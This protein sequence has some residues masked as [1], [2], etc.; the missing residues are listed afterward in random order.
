MAVIPETHKWS[1][2][3]KRDSGIPSYKWDIY[4]ILPSHKAQGL[5]QKSGGRKTVRLGGSRHPQGKN[6]CWAWEG[7]CTVMSAQTHPRL[8]QLESKQGWMGSWPSQLS[9][10]AG[11]QEGGRTEKKKTIRQ[12]YNMT[13]ASSEAKAGSFFSSLLFYHSRYMQRIWSVLKHKQNSQGANK[14]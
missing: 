14:A 4:I 7:H 9:Q 8:R 5:S 3:R 1:T 11:L 10:S 2:F 12:H 13:P 6:S